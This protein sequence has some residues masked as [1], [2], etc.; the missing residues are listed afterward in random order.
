MSPREVL[1]VPKSL[2][3]EIT[4]RCNLDCAH[5]YNVWKNDNRPPA[6]ELS[7]AETLTLLGRL[8]DQ[9]IERIAISGG[10]PFLRP[11]LEEIVSYLHGRKVN[12]LLLSNGTLLAEDRLTRLCRDNLVSLWELPLLSWRREIHD[13]LCG[14]SGAFD[15]V[16]SGIAELKTREQL[17]VAVFVATRENLADFR[18]TAELALALGVDGLMFNRFNPGGTGWKNF[19]RLVPEP[20]DLC[21]AMDQADA[22]SAEL[23]WS[24]SC[25]IAMPPC[26]FDQSRFRHLSF[27]MCSAGTENAYYTMGPLGMLRPCNHSSTV[28]GNLRHQ[29]LAELTQGQAMQDFKEARPAFCHACKFEMDCLGGCKAAAEVCL[30][31]VKRLEPYL[32]RFQEQAKKI[33]E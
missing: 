23:N 24:I 33:I 31:S 17:V 28:L 15:M 4:E 21:V 30:G 13:K 22:M 16:T 7:T 18:D 1:P 2:V 8:I 10:E 9:G 11:D 14:M 3:F 5:C 27:G 6:K 20:N 25:S 19:D 32:A 26:L 12:V 29:T